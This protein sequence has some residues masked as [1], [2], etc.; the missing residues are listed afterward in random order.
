MMCHGLD[1][2]AGGAA[3]DLRWSGSLTS[4]ETF[5]A[6][7]RDGDLLGQ[8]MPGYNDL[9]P[10]TVENIRFYLRSVAHELSRPAP[11]ERTSTPL[12]LTGGGH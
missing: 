2:I 10:D 6:I 4:K 3:P 5:F 12:P 11:Q 9:P 1:A 8:G 7:V